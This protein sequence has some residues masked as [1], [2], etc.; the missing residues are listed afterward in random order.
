M[1]SPCDLLWTHWITPESHSI[2]LLSLHWVLHHLSCFTCKLSTNIMAYLLRKERV[3]LS[4][5]LWI[6]YWSPPCCAIVVVP[7]DLNN[8]ICTGLT[9]VW[10]FG[11]YDIFSQTGSNERPIL[12][13]VQ[14]RVF[15]LPGQRQVDKFFP[16]WQYKNTPITFSFFYK[17]ESVV[18]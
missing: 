18:I 9:T 8:S 6:L 10:V 1:Q 17:L 15:L 14:H 2:T 4:L 13:S 12:R 3:P 11:D 5:M 16:P 7:V